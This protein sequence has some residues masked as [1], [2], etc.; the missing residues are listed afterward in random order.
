MRRLVVILLG[1]AALAGT[2]CASTGVPAAQNPHATSTIAPAKLEPITEEGLRK[3]L[4]QFGGHDETYAQCSAKA[5]WPTLTAAEKRGLNQPNPP[6]ALTESVLDR[7]QNVS[8]N[9]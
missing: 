1:V 6:D 2:G 5:L 9:C 4:Q 7:A 8:T 3:K